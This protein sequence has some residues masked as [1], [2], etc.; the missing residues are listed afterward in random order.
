MWTNQEGGQLLR[1]SFYGETL[2]ARIDFLMGMVVTEVLSVTEGSNM[3]APVI[4]VD[5]Q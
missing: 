4:N 5:H 1:F 3:R 2:A